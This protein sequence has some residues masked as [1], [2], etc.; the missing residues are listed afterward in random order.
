MIPYLKIIRPLNCLFVILTVGFGAYYQADLLFQLPVLFAALATFLIA[1]AGYVI[2]DFFD[3][4]IDIINRSD[5]ILPSGLIS[6]YAAKNY[7]YLLFLAGITFSILTQNE[8]CIILAIVN[9]TLLYLYSKYFK[10][11]FFVGNLVVAYNSASTFI[12]GGLSNQNIKNSLMISLLAFLYTIVR[13]IVKDVEDMEGDAEEGAK[14][15]AVLWG[16]KNSIVFAGIPAIAVI[17]LIQLFGFNHS[18]SSNT[19]IFLNLLVTLP[20]ALFFAIMFKNKKKSTLNR[21]SGLMKLDMF[22]LLIIMMIGR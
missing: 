20:L 8:Y 15:V 19:Q 9:S 7:A 6:L 18:I 5:R 11:M 3:Y 16:S 13:E 14:T 4:E 12:F 21:I 22:I 10:K 1:A 17:S 2:N